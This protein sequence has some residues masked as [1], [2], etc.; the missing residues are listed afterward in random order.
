[1]A[2]SKVALIALITLILA[3]GYTQKL[4]RRG[5]CCTMLGL[6]VAPNGN[7]VNV[8]ISQ[9]ILIFI[10]EQLRDISPLS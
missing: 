2:E 1:M 7:L 9:P 5:Y 10:R 6:N 8:F 3:R 4:L